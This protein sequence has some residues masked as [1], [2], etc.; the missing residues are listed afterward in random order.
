MSKLRGNLSECLDKAKEAFN[1][2]K[3]LRQQKEA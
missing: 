2:E 3:K 1:K